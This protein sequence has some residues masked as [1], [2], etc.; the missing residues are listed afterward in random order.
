LIPLPNSCFKHCGLGAFH[1][2]LLH[3][4][5]EIGVYWVR[6]VVETN[7]EGRFTRHQ[8]PMT[9]TA[10]A[11]PVSRGQDTH[12]GKSLLEIALQD[13]IAPI[14]VNPDLGWLWIARENPPQDRN[15]GL[16]PIVSGNDDGY[17]RLFGHRGIR[18]GRRSTRLRTGVVQ[19]S[20]SVDI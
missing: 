3:S 8:T 18:N 9:S 2:Q 14:D 4:K 13:P 1:K 17:G 16:A 6:V 20:Q 10:R 5:K 15:D 7:C 12:A 19:V 11:E